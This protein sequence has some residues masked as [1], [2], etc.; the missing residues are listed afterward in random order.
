MRRTY[1]TIM[2]LAAIGC[3]GG[4]GGTTSVSPPVFTT[5]SVSPVNSTLFTVAPGTTVQLTTT[6]LDQNSHAMSGLGA[7]TFTSSNEA[8]AT[9]SSSGLVS[10]VGAGSA[11]ITAS[12]SAAGTTHSGQS[13]I[14]VVVPPTASDVNT[15]SS[16]DQY[17]QQGNFAWDPQT[18]DIAAG[19]TVTWHLASIAHNITFDAAPNAPADVPLTANAAVGRTFSQP[20]TY[21][22]HCT[23]HNFSGTVVVH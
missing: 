10:A 17:G 22:Y 8:V 18:T 19:G 4:G 12:L 21:S 3:G 23:L 5:L 16:T 2:A 9:V 14:S 15:T 20:G 13:A 6:A 11:T 1:V 7:P